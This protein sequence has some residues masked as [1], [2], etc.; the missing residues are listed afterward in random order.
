M[1]PLWCLAFNYL[2]HFPGEVDT[3][4]NTHNARKSNYR[5]YTKL[6]NMTVHE[7]LLQCLD[8]LDS[9]EMDLFKWHLTQGINNFKIP[10]SQLEKKPRSWVILWIHCSPNTLRLVQ[11]KRDTNLFT[12]ALWRSTGQS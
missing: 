7:I 5:P 3:L 11:H 6:S 2:A 8:E 10:K 12:D 9:G 4:P 1:I